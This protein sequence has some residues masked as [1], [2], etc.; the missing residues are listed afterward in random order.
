MGGTRG[1]EDGGEDT[2]VQE[3]ALEAGR[4]RRG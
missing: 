3:D 2:F 1:D 4:F